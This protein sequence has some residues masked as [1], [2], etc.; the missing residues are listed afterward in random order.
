MTLLDFSDWWRANHDKP[1]PLVERSC[2]YMENDQRSPF[3][4]AEDE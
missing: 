4:E 2:L 3:K 1:T